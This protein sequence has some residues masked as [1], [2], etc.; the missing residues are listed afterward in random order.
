[1]TTKAKRKGRTWTAEQRRQ[2]SARGK[3]QYRQA[4]K[5]YEQ[6][7]RDE[8]L[9]AWKP[10]IKSFDDDS[11]RMALIRWVLFQA[12]R[13]VPP[14]HRDEF[15]K[16]AGEIYEFALKKFLPDLEGEEVA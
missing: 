9:A 1:M 8:R 13:F 15:R 14:E 2:A 16:G 12:N 5:A 10:T 4:V 7:Q 11:N 3:E 6:R